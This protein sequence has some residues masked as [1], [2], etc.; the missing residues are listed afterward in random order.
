MSQ[1]M[2][3]LLRVEGVNL[4]RFVFDTRDLSTNRGGGLLLLDAVA[5]VEKALAVSLGEGK[6]KSL[7]RGASMGL[8][9]VECTDPKAVLDGV[10]AALGSGIF[11]HATFVVDLVAKKDYPADVESLIA[12]NRWRQ[13]QAASL[14]VPK[15]NN[16]ADGAPISGRPAC[17]LDGLRPAQQGKDGSHTLRGKKLSE[18]TWRRRE[19]GREQKQSREQEQSFYE[20]QTGIRGLP[21]FAEHFEEI[22]TGL[23]PLEGKLAVF[24]ADGNNFGSKQAK[25]CGT[26]EKQ[27]A[28]DSYLRGK[29]K[30][31]LTDFL[32]H[33]KTVDQWRGKRKNGEAFLRF[34]TLLW[35]GDEVMFVMPASLG[36]SFAARF[37]NSLAG[38][39]L[40]D[41]NSKLPKGQ[42][43]PPTPLTHAAALVFCQHHS[44]I[45]RIKKLA[46]EQ[47]AEFAKEADRSRDSMVVAALESFDHL[48][49][50]FENAMRDRYK[51]AVDLK[52]MVMAP[53]NGK[54][55]HE[56]ISD[57]AEGVSALRRSPDFARSQLR[58]LVQSMIRKPAEASALAEIRVE[59]GRPIN[60]T[61]PKPFRN[62]S[63]DDKV[64]L[65]DRIRPCL[66]ND[67]AL[68]LQLEELWDYALPEPTP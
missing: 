67:A 32:N 29:R 57:V 61:L 21:D 42:S 59:P 66:P 6:Y 56:V 46:K 23:K 62:A 49:T 47:M 60:I 2:N 51:S 17:D 39:N 48:G 1:E 13:M 37:F 45:H 33:A 41:G 52:D 28:F 8:F 55:L 10:K 20:K 9:E 38:M 40:A 24:Y 14:A 7:S 43:F 16:A 12:A 31:F 65:V 18:T 50:G 64:T 19:Y 54:S 25:L 53:A 26:P 30:T 68:W 44:P 11:A 15:A 5:E 4:D 3:H 63:D 27:E 22:A 35:G 34:E 36:W 58:A